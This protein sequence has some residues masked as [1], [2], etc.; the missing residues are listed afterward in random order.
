MRFVTSLSVE[1]VNHESSHFWP[2][3]LNRIVI[4]VWQPDPHASTLIALGI[5]PDHGGRVLVE[6]EF[7]LALLSAFIKAVIDGVQ[8]EIHRHCHR[9]ATSAAD[10][11]FAFD[12]RHPVVKASRAV[13]AAI[14][15]DERLAEAVVT[16]SPPQRHGQ[17]DPPRDHTKR[18]CDS[19]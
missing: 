11:R 15:A 4:V 7:P 13:A 17:Y 3:G 8:G 9:I 5:D 10:H 2:H 12:P 14:R 18:E 6:A 1:R 19:P 16:P